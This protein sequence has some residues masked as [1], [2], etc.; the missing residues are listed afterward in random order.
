MRQ[1]LAALGAALLAVACSSV[2]PQGL[3]PARARWTS[4][5]LRDYAYVYDQTGFFISYTAHEVRV[6]VRADTVR[7]VR[8]AATGDSLPWSPELFPT[9][10][11]LFDRAAAAEA[12]GQLAGILYDPV[13]GYPAR[14]DLAGLPDASGSMFASQLQ[15]AGCTPGGTWGWAMNFNPGGSYTNL[16]IVVHGDS[17]AGAGVSRGIGPN[18]T[19][20]SLALSGH[21]VPTFAPPP[22]IALRLAYRSGRIVDWFGAQA[23][24]DTLTGTA[25]ENGQS[26]PL[27]FIRGKTVG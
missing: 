6:T 4:L 10:D 26:S 22:G 8:D 13:Y 23:C 11:Q 25:S 20:D 18:G 3:G 9:I 27:V 2:E 19:S 1:K 17:L 7:A 16:T 5:G 12:A 24:P 14:I 15:P 21:Y